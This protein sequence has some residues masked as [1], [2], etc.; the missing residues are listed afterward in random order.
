MLRKIRVVPLAAESF[1]VRSMCTYVGTPEVKVLLD[2]GASL[3]PSRFGF[4]PH[5]REYEAMAECRERISKAAEE[6]DVVTV[7]H[8]HFDHHTPSFVDWFCNWSSAEAARQIYAGKLVLVKDYRAVI[9]FSQRRRGWM[10]KKTC[11][12]HA[13]R[14]EVADGRT[15]EFGQTKVKFSEPVFHGAENTPL[16]WILMTTIQHSGEKVLFAPDVQGPMCDHTLKLILGERPQLIIVGGP[17]HYLAGFRVSE[18]HIQC[19]MRNLE[20]LVKNVPLTILE[21]HILRDERWREL[22]QPIFGAAS[23][24]GHVVVTAAEF[25]GKKNNLLEFRRKPLFETEPPSLGF[26]KWMKLPLSERK[27]IGPPT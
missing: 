19:G 15:F 9:N 21:H 16:G 8:Y 14:L 11:G 7:S 17:P 18:D 23:K 22:S 27:T 5:P 4:P 6:V 25:L 10:F 3:G 13:A 24:K 20:T 12:R 1:G 26:E 2:A